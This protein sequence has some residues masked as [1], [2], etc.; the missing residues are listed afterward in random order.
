VTVE[1]SRAFI[2]RSEA[3]AWR[4]ALQVVGHEINNSLAPVTSLL[5][6]AR[7]MTSTPAM[8]HRLDPVLETIEERVHHLRTFLDSYA[9]LARLP[10]PVKAD[11]EWKPFLS[12]LSGLYAFQLEAASLAVPGAFDRAQIQQVLI[13]LLKNAHEAGGAAEQIRLRIETRNELIISVLDR[14]PGMKPEHLA[15]VG[16]PFFTT[17]RSGSGIGLHLCREIAAAHGGSLELVPRSGGG[18]A[19]S[20]H[21]P[22]S[23][24]R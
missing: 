11:V 17:K 18:I 19:A 12:E 7:L 10:S 20:L 23:T 15:R 8:L 13:N 16:E 3:E 4:N 24:R 6:S 14:G 21:L 9:R 1:E 2:G 22:L 5:H